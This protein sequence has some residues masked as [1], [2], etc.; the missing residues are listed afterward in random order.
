MRG[1]RNRFAAK[2]TYRLPVR[3]AICT[4]KATYATAQVTDGIPAIS[5]PA[6]ILADPLIFYNA[7]LYLG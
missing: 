3:R 2:T 4:E 7:L 5:L 1:R 6:W